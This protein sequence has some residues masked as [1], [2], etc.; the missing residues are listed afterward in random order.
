VPSSPA[1]EVGEQGV[2]P[3]KLGFEFEP[4][5]FLIQ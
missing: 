2:V 3:W 5:D 1:K 4:W